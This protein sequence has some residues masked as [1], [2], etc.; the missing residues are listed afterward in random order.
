MDAGSS[1]RAIQLSAL[2]NSA[3]QEPLEDSSHSK[4]PLPA[5]NRWFGSRLE[6]PSATAPDPTP[7]AAPAPKEEPPKE[8]PPK[9]EEEPKDFLTDAFFSEEVSLP[10]FLGSLGGNS[11]FLRPTT[12]AAASADVAAGRDAGTCNAS[13]KN[14]SLSPAS[15]NATLNLEAEPCLLASALSTGPDTVVY[16]GWLS[17]L[18]VHRW[19][20]A[21]LL[22]ED[23]L[24]QPPDLLF[25]PSPDHGAV[26][27][28][29]SSS[30]S[31]GDEA[32][33][34]PAAGF[35]TTHHWVRAGTLGAAFVDE[36]GRVT[37]WWMSTAR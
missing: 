8:E 35:A 9:E 34:Q 31:A 3:L 7:A 30:I 33:G 11:S 12:G 29:H 19:D 10:S 16:A 24:R 27:Y 2:T 37:L 17:P 28:G 18:P 1:S 14:L 25:D 13:Y 6:E 15:F 26:T 36:S 32:A 21:K 5:I 22:S 4:A 20:T 23:N